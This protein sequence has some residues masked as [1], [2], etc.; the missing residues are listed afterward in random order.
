MRLLAVFLAI[1][2]TSCEILRT[3]TGGS[4]QLSPGPTEI[5]AQVQ[6]AMCKIACELSYSASEDSSLTVEGIRR[7]NARYRSLG[8]E[9]RNWC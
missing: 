7:W 8:C 3:A 6:A 4:P 1:P 5:E 2:L 9:K